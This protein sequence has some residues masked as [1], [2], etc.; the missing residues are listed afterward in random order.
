MVPL[1]VPTVKILSEWGCNFEHAIFYPSFQFFLDFVSS[2]I[3]GCEKSSKFQQI[4][5]C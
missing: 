3:K 1:V 4:A 5:E 2:I